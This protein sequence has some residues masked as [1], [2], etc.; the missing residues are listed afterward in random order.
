MFP[1]SFSIFLRLLKPLRSTTCATELLTF[2]KVHSYIQKNKN[3][4]LS[5]VQSKQ[6]MCIKY[7]LTKISL[8]VKRN[9]LMAFTNKIY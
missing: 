5:T 1:K 9:K 8:K 4:L 7:Y 3:Y 2:T 6:E